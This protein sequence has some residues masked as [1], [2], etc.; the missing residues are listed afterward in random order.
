[1]LQ[2]KK[3]SRECREIKFGDEKNFISINRM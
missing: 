2:K 3:S 1:M